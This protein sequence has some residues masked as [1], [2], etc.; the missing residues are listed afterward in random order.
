MEKLCRK[1]SLLANDGGVIRL[2]FLVKGRLVV[3]PEI[4]RGQIEAAFAADRDSVYARLPGAQLIREPVIDRRTMKYTGDYIYQVMPPLDAAALIEDNIEELVAGPYALSVE[5]CLDYLESILAGLKHNLKLAARVLELCRLTSEYPDALLDGWFASLSSAFSR[6]AARQMVDN[7]LSLWG[8]PGRD[9]LGGWVELPSKVSP[10]LLPTLATP[11]F[12]R[13]TLAN[14][15]SAKTRLRAMPT[16]QLHITAGN[17]LE[18]PIISVLRAVLTKSAA[19]IKL[20]YGATLTGALCSIAASAVAPDH[21]LTRHLSMVYWPGGD[22]GIEGVLFQPDAFDRIIVWGNPETVSSVQ[23]RALF[24]RL[25]TLNPRYGV[26][27]IGREAFSAKALPEAAA[28]AAT[29][30]MIYNQKAC[31]SSLL[32]YIEAGEKEADEYAEALR[33][34]LVKWDEALHNFV[35]PAARGQLKRMRHGRYAHARW[36]INKRQGEFSSGVLVVPGEFD[37]LEHPMCRL[38][39]VRPMAKLEEALQ[40]L[41]SA[42]S[43]VGI[44]PEERRQ[45]LRDKVLARGVSNVLPLGQCERVFAGMPHDGMIVLSQLVDWKNA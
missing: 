34:A 19:A 40:Y 45:A 6:Q 3:P 35:A 24:T 37:V 16:R 9:F 13:S 15:G 4:S 29:D 5:D 1:H 36:Y 28:R 8:K 14:Q 22:E 38:V 39:V 30:V 32:H 25:I 17:A 42:V 23:S 27:L 11:I 43:T 2:P 21:P 33:Q 31:T 10:G 44:Y 7:E 26:S 20:P 41:Q 12:G 18:I